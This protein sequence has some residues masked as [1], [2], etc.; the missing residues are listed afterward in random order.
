MTKRFAALASVLVAA[1]V[2]AAQHVSW[3]WT[4]R[5]P[6]V[7]LA[8]YPELVRVDPDV[9]AE[10]P[11]DFNPRNPAAKIR[12]EEIAATL[13]RIARRGTQGRLA[14]LRRLVELP[15]P[16]VRFLHFE[17]PA[18]DASSEPVACWVRA[19]E[20]PVVDAVLL[21]IAAD[22]AIASPEQRTA[23]VALARPGSDAAFDAYCGLIVDPHVRPE[24]RLAALLRFDRL[25]RSPPARLRE[26]LYEADDRLAA[27]SAIVLAALGDLEAPSLVL[28]AL[29][30]SQTLDEPGIGDACVRA[31]ARFGTECGELP[32]Y[33]PSDRRR[34]EAARVATE[35]ERRLHENPA[36]RDT[37]FERRRAAY[38]ASSRR[39]RELAQT[40]DDVL[41][42]PPDDFDLGAALLERSDGATHRFETELETL[43]RLAYIVRRDAGPQPTPERWI[44]AMNARLLSSSAE[45]TQDARPSSLPYVLATHH[46]NCMGFSS[47]YLAVGERLGL[48]LH[49]VDAPQHV[50]VRWDDGTLRRNVECTERGIERS[51][52]WY[53]EGG[54]IGARIALADR[55]RA[56][57]RNLTKREFLSLA[58]VNEALTPPVDG[59]RSVRFL[60]RALELDPGNAT[61]LVVRATHRKAAAQFGAAVEDLR[62]AAKLRTIAPGEVL[63]AV[64]VLLAAGCDQEALQVAEAAAGLAPRSQRTAAARARALVRLGRIGDARACIDSVMAGPPDGDLLVADGQVRVESGD[65]TW[66][67]RLASTVRDPVTHPALHFELARRLL[68]EHR[69]RAEDASLVLAEI[70]G[71]ATE[72]N[73][74]RGRRSPQGRL[75]YWADGESGVRADRR[76]Y[77][78][79]L[80]RV[81]RALGDERGATE[82][83]KSLST[84]DE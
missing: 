19:S 7:A 26:L 20:D 41:S 28:H 25:E 39:Q 44:A 32:A 46:G 66:R 16:Q 34:E 68:D 78:S 51:D 62:A 69:G 29:R 64:D 75:R 17:G 82:A 43:D 33:G 37:E 84:I 67:R 83:E 56:Y 40:F 27:Q 73:D 14:V 35:F 50:F 38:L 53:A 70:A 65:P 15:Q 77:F 22:N 49:G 3:R 79:L 18:G 11:A 24:V 60:D 1:A 6:S 48:P 52:S 80:A 5:L 61:A 10:L 9:L 4:V 13:D 21:R 57:L 30:T 76:Q 71:L 81:R 12:R 8:R 58:A 2:L 54:G 72:T 74:T 36:L 42:A 31:L 55:G 63:A 23:V 47:L 45:A 59:E